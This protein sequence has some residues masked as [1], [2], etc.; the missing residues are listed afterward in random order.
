M[1][2]VF[3]GQNGSFSFYLIFNLAHKSTATIRRRLFKWMY[4]ISPLKV[5]ILIFLTNLKKQLRRL[6]TPTFVPFEFCVSPSVPFRCVHIRSGPTGCGYRGFF[7][8]F[9]WQSGI[10]FRILNYSL[11]KSEIRKVLLLIIVTGKLA[12]VYPFLV[13]GD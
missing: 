5:E 9:L 11:P 7:N 3:F 12:P 6:P 4:Q 10:I 1:V 8:T 2:S 13:G